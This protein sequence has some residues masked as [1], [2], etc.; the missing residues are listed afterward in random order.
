MWIL[1]SRHER[2]VE[3]LHREI[4]GLQKRLTRAHEWNNATTAKNIKLQK[5]L[6]PFQRKRGDG[7]RFV[8]RA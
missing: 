7:G 3:A 6:A 8:G 2:E 5:A 4:D 1:K